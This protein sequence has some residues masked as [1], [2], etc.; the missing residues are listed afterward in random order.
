[1]LSDVGPHDEVYN[2]LIQDYVFEDSNINDVIA[3]Q[4][5]FRMNTGLQRYQQDRSPVS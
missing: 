1:M 2:A 5:S 3:V 4:D